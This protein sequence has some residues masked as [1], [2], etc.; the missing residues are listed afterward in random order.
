MAWFFTRFSKR[1]RG[2]AIQVGQLVAD[3]YRIESFIAEGGM[4]MV[5]GAVHTTLGQRVA[6]KFLKDELAERPDLVERFINEAR[7]FGRLSGD[8]VARV[9]DVGMMD[10]LPFMVLERLRGRDLHAIVAKT[11]AQEIQTA[12]DWTL[13]ACEALAEAHCAGIVHRDIKLENLFL[14]ERPDGR[15][16]IK[17]LDFG[18]S[19]QAGLRVR[20]LT[21]PNVPMGSPYSMSPEQIRAPSTADAR[22]DIWG[23]GVVLYELLSGINP[24]EGEAQSDIY[25][26]V[27]RYGP[28]PLRKL[29]P[30][31]PPGLEATVMRCLHKDPDRRFHDVFALGKALVPYGPAS[32][33]DS[34]RRTRR[35]FDTKASVR[36]AATD[37]LSALDGLVLNAQAKSDPGLVPFRT[38]WPRRALLLVSLA[39]CGAAVTLSVPN[40]RELAHSGSRAVRGFMGLQELEPGAVIEPDVSFSVRPLMTGEPPLPKL[41]TAQSEREIALLEL[42]RPSAQKRLRPRSR[43]AKDDD[44]PAPHP[45]PASPAASVPEEAEETPTKTAEPVALG[46]GDSLPESEPLEPNKEQEQPVQ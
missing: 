5:F 15:S 41:T 29:R 19:K 37:S 40:G 35:V 45:T 46:D 38:D 33:P 2:P 20:H 24:F 28:R 17:L 13:Q 30:E 1:K 10:G 21:D 34:L 36:N 6:I 9:L 3:K 4:S 44:T 16:L 12:V 7:A 22:T 42:P 25:V 11:G 43:D 14:A 32:A 18:I 31:I 39:L 8:H 26:N 27:L 23:L